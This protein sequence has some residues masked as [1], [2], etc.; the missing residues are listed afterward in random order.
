MVRFAPS[1]TANDINTFLNAHKAAI[2]EGPK[3]GGMYRVRLAVPALPKEQL[4]RVIREMKGETNVV[5]FIAVV[6]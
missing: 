2:I 4:D 5:S 1:A 6:E 3:A